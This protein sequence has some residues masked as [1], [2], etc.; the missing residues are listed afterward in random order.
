M[1]T[2]NGIAIRQCISCLVVEAIEVDSLD[3]DTGECPECREERLDRDIPLCQQGITGHD[4]TRG[5]CWESP[6]WKG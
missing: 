3:E 5:C 6:H 1:I 2:L 4:I